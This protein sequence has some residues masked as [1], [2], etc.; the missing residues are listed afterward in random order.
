MLFLGFM[1]YVW[2]QS[3]LMLNHFDSTSFSPLFKEM[4]ITWIFVIMLT[5]TDTVISFPFSVY[6]TFVLEEKHGFNKSTFGL[7]LVSSFCL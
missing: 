5:L 2:D 4:V 7:F 3:R 6:K 1:P